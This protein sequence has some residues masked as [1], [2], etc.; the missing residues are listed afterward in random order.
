MFK[1]KLFLIPALCV[2]A[3]ACSTET[4]IIEEKEEVVEIVPEKFLTKFKFI[5]ANNASSYGDDA[6]ISVINHAG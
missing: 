1:T 2:A 6:S 5:T 3:W 4:S